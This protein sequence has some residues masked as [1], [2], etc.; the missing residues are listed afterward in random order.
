MNEPSPPSSEHPEG[1]APEHRR[2]RWQF[3]LR[4]M[5]LATALAACL[6]AAIGWQIQM[7]HRRTHAEEM[8]RSLDLRGLLAELPAAD[9]LGFGCDGGGQ[10]NAPWVSREDYHYWLKTS[11]TAELPD[12]ILSRLENATVGRLAELGASVDGTDPLAGKQYSHE[13]RR[14]GP[15]TSG[16]QIIYRYGPVQ[17]SIVFR[18][19]EFETEPL[20]DG[21]RYLA[22][23]WVNHVQFR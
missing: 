7:R 3:S 21:E 11:A 2:A 17:G 5:L 1:A 12:D 6:F 18:L 8:V 4:E 20:P 16:V 19:I 14:L 15:N 10:E 22:Y 9:G 13:Y 23:V